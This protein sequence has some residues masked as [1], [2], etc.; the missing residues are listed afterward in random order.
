[1]KW[2]IEDCAGEIEAKSVIHTVRS[3][4][5]TLVIEYLPADVCTLC[6]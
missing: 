5:R 2:H 6:G 1:M 3:K 4:G